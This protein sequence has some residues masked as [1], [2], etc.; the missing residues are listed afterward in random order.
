MNGFK[1]K[2]P[3]FTFPRIPPFAKGGI[4]DPLEEFEV[5]KNGGF[6]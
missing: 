4:R 2:S 5:Q 6:A 1:I 3:L